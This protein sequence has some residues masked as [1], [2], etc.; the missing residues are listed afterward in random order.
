ML[1]ANEVM[2]F[3]R[4]SRDI[5]GYYSAAGKR[6]YSGYTI[7]YDGKYTQDKQNREDR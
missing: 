2:L 3:K 6:K 1:K 7:A 5:Q 4:I